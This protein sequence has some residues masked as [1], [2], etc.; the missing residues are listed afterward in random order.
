M[1]HASGQSADV[2][3]FWEGAPTDFDP[4]LTGLRTREIVPSESSTHFARSQDT[5]RTT[6]SYSLPY[7]LAE[8]DPAPAV[9]AEL[10]SE[11]NLR[12]HISWDGLVDHITVV[13]FCSGNMHSPTLRNVLISRVEVCFS[14]QEPQNMPAVGDTLSGRYLWLIVTGAIGAFAFGYGTG[15]NDVANAFGTSVGAK[16][17]RYR[18]RTLCHI[19]ICGS[20]FVKPLCAVQSMQTW[21]TT[22]N[23]L[24]QWNR[25]SEN[26]HYAFP[27]IFQETKSKST[28]VMR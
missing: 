10:L 9:A 2:G 12:L 14:F 7:W 22:L 6:S 21:R 13:H 4:L 20:F 17:L 8:S 1:P 16:T 19:T 5:L 24:G 27:L 28:G 25:L 26:N 11:V 15:S 23:R 3:N 18:N